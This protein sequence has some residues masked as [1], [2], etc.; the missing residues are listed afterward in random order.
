[1]A[2]DN[3]NNSRENKADWKQWIPVVI[4]VGPVLGYGLA[5]VYE[6][7]YFNFYKIPTDFIVLNWTTVLVAVAASLAALYFLV[8]VLAILALIKPLKMNNLGGKIFFIFII[9]I[10][11]LF[12]A[13]KYLT[14]AETEQVGIIFALFAAFIF[15]VP[16][17]NAQFEKQARIRNKN[18]P[19]TGEEEAIMANIRKV[20]ASKYFNYGFLTL[21]LLVALFTFSYLGGRS[22]GLDPQTVYVPSS[23]PQLVVLKITGDN[24]ICAPIINTY[25]DKYGQNYYILSQEFYL[26]QT[27]EADL[28]I[29]AIGLGYVQI[30][31]SP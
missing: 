16:W 29:K 11:L 2:D 15:L 31:S 30:S 8:W 10:V 22:G 3:K 7:G 6:L 27:D 24:L 14:T 1:M 26:L 28:S 5:Y 23:N 18:Q 13:M 4:A 9:F 25:T 12:I 17:L 20:I 19:V 21:G